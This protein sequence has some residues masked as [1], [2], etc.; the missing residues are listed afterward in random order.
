LARL[1]GEPGRELHALDLVSDRGGDGR[2][3]TEAAAREA[4]LSPTGLGDAGAVLDDRAKAAY[5]KR[6]VELE[7]EIAEAE[8][9][10]DPERVARAKE[11]LQF[12]ARELAAATGLGGRDRRAASA[13]E[14]ARLSSTRAIRAAMARIAEHSP[15]LGRHLDRTVRTGTFCSYTPDPRAPIAWRTS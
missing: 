14:R 7:E 3:T 15:D 9:W 8:S 1:L 11:E 6:V 5:R 12:L 10:N 4:G 2:Q 13:A